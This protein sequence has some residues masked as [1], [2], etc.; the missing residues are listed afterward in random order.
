MINIRYSWKATGSGGYRNV[1]DDGSLPGV[2]VIV[3]LIIYYV[4]ISLCLRTAVH[5]SHLEATALTLQAVTTNAYAVVAKTGCGGS[6]I[7][8]IAV[9]LGNFA[10]GEWVTQFQQEADV[11]IEKS[12]QLL[13]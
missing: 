8:A 10:K 12:K 6:A 1:L 5:D 4:Q 9:A 2:K 3:N 7:C 13:F 11:M